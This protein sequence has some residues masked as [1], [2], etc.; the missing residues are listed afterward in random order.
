MTAPDTSDEDLAGRVQQGAR[1]AFGVLMDRYE[2]RIL[3][4]GRKFLSDTEDIKD[5]TQEI[6]IK[7]Y[8]NIRSFDAE[9]RFSPWLYRIAHNAFINHMRKKSPLRIFSFDLD[10]LMPHATAPRRA[11]QDADTADMR[12]ILDTALSSLDA[13]YREPLVLH[14]FE[15][16]NYREI[17]DI[18][19]LP[20]S[21]VGVRLAR[22]KAML[23]KVVGADKTI[24]YG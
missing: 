23:S 17:A 4:Y 21:T 1:D 14:Y 20:L 19:R 8:V 12:R 13:K 7:A 24:L 15:E 10:A 2:P 18:M 6:F 11:D 3:R 16:M 22:G 9:R 5:L